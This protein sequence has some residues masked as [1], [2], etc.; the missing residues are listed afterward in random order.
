[1][2]HEL[3]NLTMTLAGFRCLWCKLGARLLED[4]F[5]LLLFQWNKWE[6]SARSLLRR[7]RLHLN[8]AAHF[9]LCH[10]VSRP[11][12]LDHSFWLT[13]HGHGHC[14]LWS[15]QGS[16]AR[17]SKGARQGQARQRETQSPYS[18][19]PT[20]ETPHPPWQWREKMQRKHKG[21]LNCNDKLESL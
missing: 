10:P 6:L 1:M 18:C 12:A 4:Y 14:T 21:V 11:P 19:A 3:L 7:V 8:R 17:K 16:A 15:W 9:L 2:S 20:W 5:F 13:E